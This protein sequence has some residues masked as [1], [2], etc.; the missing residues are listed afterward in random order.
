[1]TKFDP[2]PLILEVVHS[3]AELK[4]LQRNDGKRRT[5]K[6]KMGKL[7]G[8][9]GKDVMASGFMNLRGDRCHNVRRS[10][11]HEATRIVPRHHIQTNIISKNI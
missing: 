6:T 7:L 10:K 8:Y 3:V 4:F 9:K 11:R 1:M 5:S 2:I